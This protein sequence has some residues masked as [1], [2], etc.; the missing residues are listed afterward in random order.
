MTS[1]VDLG[2]P[3]SG[4][5]ARRP[6]LLAAASGARPLAASVSSRDR[7]VFAAVERTA[8]VVD[9]EPSVRSL[10]T[11]VLAR[12]GWRVVEAS[13][14]RDALDLAGR[15]R[16]DLV[17]TDYDMPYLTGIELTE[18]LRITQ[19]ELPVLLI[20]GHSDVAPRFLA[21]P[22]GRVDFSAKPFAIDDLLCR[23]DGLVSDR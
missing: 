7:V 12:R 18:Q 4:R 8:L 19:S 21:L 20:S 3:A 11:K 5:A 10:V 9:D 15:G 14:G 1:Q 6:S 22:G 16:F 2:D 17:V 23:I 13:N